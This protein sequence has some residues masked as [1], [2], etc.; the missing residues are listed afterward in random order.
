MYVDALGDTRL[1]DN[2]RLAI[3]FA[4]GARNWEGQ[5]GEGPIVLRWDNLLDDK[6]WIIPY[7]FDETLGQFVTITCGITNE[8]VGLR[9][10][11]VCSHR[12]NDLH[13]TN[14]C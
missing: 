1:E 4:I 5:P 7:E 10:C 13:P 8:S 11:I 14:Q 9:V 2:T 12:S 6:K 3:E